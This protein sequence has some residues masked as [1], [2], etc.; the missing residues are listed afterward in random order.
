MKQIRQGQI[1]HQVC[2]RITATLLSD[3]PLY[4]FC[5]LKMGRWTTLNPVEEEGG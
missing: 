4:G 2:R 5:N 3:V 1:T